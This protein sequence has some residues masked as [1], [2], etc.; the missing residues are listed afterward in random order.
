[1][2]LIAQHPDEVFQ[3]VSAAYDMNG[4]RRSLTPRVGGVRPWNIFYCYQR[5]TDRGLLY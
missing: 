5:L 2:T 4:G 3:Y 1:M